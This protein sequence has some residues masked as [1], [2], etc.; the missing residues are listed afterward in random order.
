MYKP[1]IC[2]LLFI[3]YCLC[4]K[5]KYGIELGYYENGNVNSNFKWKTINV[6]E[7]S[8]DFKNIT[9]Y[10]VK[11]KD[12]YCFRLYYKNK[13]NKQ[14]Y[15]YAVQDDKYYYFGDYKELFTVNVC[16]TNRNNTKC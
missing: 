16:K 1:F 6:D 10:R 4:V 8:D 15:L 14:K 9:A 7:C 11:S 5:T 3:S 2:I 13:Y 12:D